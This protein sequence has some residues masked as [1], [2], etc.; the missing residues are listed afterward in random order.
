MSIQIHHGPPGSYKTSGAIQDTFI[1]AAKELRTIVTNVRGLDC[2]QRVSEVLELGEE[3]DLIHIDTSTEAGRLKL[4][5]WFH[6]APKGA[7]ILIDEIN[8]I[9]PT[10]WRDS[11]LSEFD[12]PGG[13]DKAM[14]DQRPATVK[15]AFEMHRHHNFDFCVTTPHI[16]KVHSIIRQ[17]SEGAY[18]HKNQAT[19]G[20]KGIY[21]EI[22]HMADDNGKTSGCQISIKQRRVK[23]HVFKLYSSTSTGKTQDTISGQNVFT[24]FTVIGFI[25]L[26]LLGVG[27][28]Y[29]AGP[30][31]TIS[32]ALDSKEDSQQPPVS[33]ESPAKS[34]NT[35]TVNKAVHNTKRVNDFLDPY[36][37]TYVG[38]FGYAP[39]GQH[40]FELE[41]NSKVLT[42]T[43]REIE[44][45]GYQIVSITECVYK[46]TRNTTEK[47]VTCPM[48]DFD[49]S[50]SQP[51]QDISQQFKI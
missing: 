34:S 38:Q 16:N 1:P 8:T 29:N 3:T 5:T 21:Q 17:C 33:N 51:S 37:V 41:K 50:K 9:Y 47:I 25:S 46:I 30:P 4:A 24:N 12:Y 44:K 45:L 18:R 7:F 22:F 32:Q 36:N 23:K 19:I 11:K 27:L 20:L 26:F 40:H 42:M 13:I 35:H 10:E 39:F 31:K 48:N 43:K 28:L 2:G 6:W 49:N 15:E 14:E